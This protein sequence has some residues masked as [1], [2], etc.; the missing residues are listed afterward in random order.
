MNIF[1][2]TPLYIAIDE[3]NQEFVKYLLKKKADPNIIDYEGNTTLIKACSNDKIEIVKAILKSS[4]LAN[5]VNIKNNK[6]ITIYWIIH[7]TPLIK[8][9]QGCQDAVKLLVEKG[10]DVNAKDYSNNRVRFNSF[11]FLYDTSSLCIQKRVFWS[12]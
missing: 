2:E 10:A 3:N 6:G 9:C 11:I 8:A 5:I 4:S 7:E 12:C 1:D